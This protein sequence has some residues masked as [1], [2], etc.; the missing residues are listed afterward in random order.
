M[1]KLFLALALASVSAGA[2][3][4]VSVGSVAPD[5][6]LTDINGQTQHLYSYLD[7]GYTVIIDVSAAWCGPCW[8]AHNSHVFDNLM[9]HYGP[10]GTTT[11]KKIM[12]LFIEGESTNTTAQLHGTSSGSS[13][14]TFSQGDWVTGTNYPIIDNASQ[15]GNYLYGGFPSFTVIGR[16]RLVYSANAGYG[17]SMG[18]ESYWLNIVNLAP[19]YP[20][21][22][23]VD[24]KAVPYNGN[25]LFICNATPTVKFQNYSKTSSITSATINVKNGTSTVKSQSWTGNLAPYAVASVPVASFPASTG[26]YTFEV[27]VNSDS[28]PSN[29][30][31]SAFP[32]TV[33]SASNA[34]TSPWNQDFESST[35]TLP[36]PMTTTDPDNIFPFKQNSSYQVIG[37]TGSLTTAIAIQYQG[38][39]G[40]ADIML[41]NFNTA[42]AANV[43][44]DFDWSHAAVNGSNDK[45]EV[46]VSNDCGAT[47]NTAW[48][49]AGSA[50]TTHADVSGIYLPAAAG[51]WR[52]K[53]AIL[54]ATKGS[55][56]V[57]KFVATSGGG[58]YGWLD[59]LKITNTTGVENVL[60]ASSVS[61]YPNPAREMAK[62][63]FTLSQKSNVTINVTDALGRTVATVANGMM[64]QGVQSVD[65]PTANL[66]AGV[67]NVS[68]QTEEGNLTQ[69]LSVVK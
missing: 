2:Y 46:K 58:Q 44:L 65:I 34:L 16:D 50:L 13:Y 20:P 37:A 9:T 14:A 23:T 48:S 56:M 64:N 4:Q 40:S 35:T 19:N 12:V 38:M 5:F 51:D 66:S 63:E 42:S 17:S 31:S 36:S 49:A 30:V 21:S 55:N 3:A 62:L 8:S 1:K 33:F 18:A 67:Y 52:H 24:A 15:N 10:N 29:N 60:N 28:Q 69:R 47:W 53:T 68:I 57:V 45:L 26:N 6:T 39:S 7:S 22:T 25:N 41:G 59:N 27:V 43:A 61:L 11:P 54:T 32:L